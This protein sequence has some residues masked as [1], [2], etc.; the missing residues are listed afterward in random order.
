MYDLAV[1]VN[2]VS[3]FLNIVSSLVTAVI[4]ILEVFN[5]L[6]IMQEKLHERNVNN[7]LKFSCKYVSHLLLNDYHFFKQP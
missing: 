4:Y 7:P 3:S 2:T 6:Y 1:D 5:S